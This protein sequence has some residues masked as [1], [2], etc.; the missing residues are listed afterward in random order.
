MFQR[1]IEAKLYNVTTTIVVTPMFYFFFF[2]PFFL[3]LSPFLPPFLPLPCFIIILNK[4]I[5]HIGEIYLIVFYNHQLILNN[6]EEHDKN[7]WM[8]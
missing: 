1:C 6:F 2:P 3:P 4:E 5:P 7:S 8:L